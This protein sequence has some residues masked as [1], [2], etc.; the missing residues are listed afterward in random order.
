MSVS[1]IIQNKPQTRSRGPRGPP[2]GPRALLH[3]VTCWEGG[4]LGPPKNAAPGGPRGPLG[5]VPAA[6]RRPTAA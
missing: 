6:H 1:F 3:E 2:K 4:P 5:Y